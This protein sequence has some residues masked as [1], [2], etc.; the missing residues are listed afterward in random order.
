MTGAERPGGCRPAAGPTNLK[1]PGQRAE[2]KTR[3]QPRPFGPGRGGPGPTGREVTEGR[4]DGAG[5]G[6]AAAGAAGDRRREQGW[7][8]GAT[9]GRTCLL[10]FS[11]QPC[12]LTSEPGTRSTTVRHK[13]TCFTDFSLVRAHSCN[14]DGGQRPAGVRSSRQSH[15][16][17]G[18]RRE[19]TS[20]PGTRSRL[21]RGSVPTGTAVAGALGPPWV[22]S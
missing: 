20:A 9:R 3:T 12:S 16:V 19:A 15:N 18:A 17:A 5:V 22:P 6:E 1:R 10:S 2:D 11:R 14:A 13:S 4:K 21:E 8:E 7:G